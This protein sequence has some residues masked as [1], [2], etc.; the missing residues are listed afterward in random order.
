[1]AGDRAPALKGLRILVTRPADLAGELCKM[2]EQRGGVPIEYP[3]FE[4][5]PVIAD[6]KLQAITSD[7]G[8][9]QAMIFVSR[10][11][12]RYGLPH[13][14]DRLRDEH[15]G[16]FAV[17]QSTAEALKQAGFTRVF[18]PAGGAGS[19]PLLEL[20][21]LNRVLDSHARILIV[22]G[23]SGREFLARELIDRGATVDYAEVYERESPCYDKQYET[24]FWEENS[25]DII[26]LTSRDAVDKLLQRIPAEYRHKALE[27]RSVVMSE[28]VAGYV[29]EQGF[30][31]EPAIIDRPDDHGIVGKCVDIAG[32]LRT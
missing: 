11:A 25:P 16:L 30:R 21:E 26:I 15:P 13:F 12:V 7:P 19:E 20:P 14:G 4:I 32:S 27:A 2:I 24:G 6:E 8:K 1:M 23:Q 3:L 29:T 17:G 10:N 18:F 5:R 9:Y 28:R 31:H 22:R